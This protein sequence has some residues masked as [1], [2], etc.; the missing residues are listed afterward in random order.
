[1]ITPPIGHLNL[2]G[3]AQDHAL[4]ANLPSGVDLFLHP[5]S[6]PAAPPP[7]QPAGRFPAKGECRAL[8]GERLD[9]IEENIPP[10]PR[11]L[12]MWIPAAAGASED[13]T[14]RAGGAS[15]RQP[16]K[17]ARPL[18]NRQLAVV[19][20]HLERRIAA[21]LRRVANHGTLR[22]P[23]AI[24]ARNA[25]AHPAPQAPKLRCAPDAHATAKA[26]AASSSRCSRHRQGQRR[27]QQQRNR[28]QPLT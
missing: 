17:N 22:R 15:R 23:T 18:S 19:P 3:V 24:E 16:P 20:A 8:M 25:A 2:L 12:R 27:Q 4:F 28:R 26:N 13:Q 14:R 5:Q 1:M 21:R 11:R 10:P 9:A 6:S 7:C